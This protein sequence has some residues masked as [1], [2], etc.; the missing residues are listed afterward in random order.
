M[1]WCITEKYTKFPYQT[2]SKF[3]SPKVLGFNRSDMLCVLSDDSIQNMDS[4]IINFTTLK[5]FE[6]F[7]KVMLF[8][9]P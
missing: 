3:S 9:A 2:V 7:G 5:T 4:G 6:A 8:K 1:K